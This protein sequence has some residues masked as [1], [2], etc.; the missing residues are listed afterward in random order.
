MEGKLDDVIAKFKTE[1]LGRAAKKKRRPGK[2]DTIIFGALVRELKGKTYCAYLHERGVRPRWESASASTYPRGYEAGDP[3]RKKIQDEKT[4]AKTRMNDYDASY[5]L[6]AF[7]NHLRNEFD[8]LSRLLNSHNASK[9][10]GTR[11]PLNTIE[12]CVI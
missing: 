4:R 7:I 8:E 12:D 9:T 3:W 1:S 2:R 6:D 10:V 11:T 5:L